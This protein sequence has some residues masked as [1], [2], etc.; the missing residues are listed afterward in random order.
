MTKYNCWF[1]EYECFI[2]LLISL[3]P[4]GI[5]YALATWDGKSALSIVTDYNSEGF[6]EY[7]LKE[8]LTFLQVEVLILDLSR[9]LQDKK[10]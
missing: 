9:M 2:R 1:Y 7:L 8:I 3:E 10:A 4:L 5:F 6:F